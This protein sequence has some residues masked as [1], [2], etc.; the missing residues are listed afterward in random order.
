VHN[1]HGAHGIFTFLS[2]RDSIPVRLRTDI[3]TV[4]KVVTATTGTAMMQPV[5]EHKS[6]RGDDTN[7]DDGDNE[8]YDEL[9]NTNPIENANHNNTTT[10]ATPPHSKQS[11]TQTIQQS[12]LS[13]P[14]PPSKMRPTLSSSSKKTTYL[15]P[16]TSKM[17]STTS[18]TNTTSTK[19]TNNDM[20]LLQQGL[21]RNMTTSKQRQQ[22]Q[23]NPTLLVFDESLMIKST[24]K[25]LTTYETPP[26]KEM[27]TLYH[28]S[29]KLQ[30]SISSLL[31]SPFS[32]QEK[33]YKTIYFIRHGESL[34]Q[35]ATTHDRRHNEKLKDCGLSPWGIRQSQQQLRH[36]FVHQQQ[37]SNN[38]VELILCSPLTRAIQT[39]ILA[40]GSDMEDE[41]AVAT[42]GHAIPSVDQKSD[43][44][45]R[46]SAS[47][48]SA[49]T[50]T[51]SATVTKSK[52]SSPKILI[53]YHLREM[54]S[55][56]P[57]NQPRT[58]KQVCDYLIRVGTIRNRQQWDTL[59]DTVTLQP[60]PPS[61][62]SSLIYYSY[63]KSVSPSPNKMNRSYPSNNGKSNVS[64]IENNAY[65]AAASST[66]HGSW[67]YYSRNGTAVDTVPSVVRRDYI[68]YMLQWI[69]VHRHET[70]IAIVCH[71]HVI[72]AALLSSSSSSMSN[73]GDHD[74]RKSN[75]STT[76]KKTRH[77]TTPIKKNVDLRPE[78]AQPIKCYLC[79]WTGQIILASHIDDFK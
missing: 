10:T 41:A 43:H 50:V 20:V 22:Q 34:G 26:K 69:A 71:Y 59:V 33:R 61:S 24:A 2:E 16:V 77:M 67:P 37:N 6:P 31:T 60:P 54:G 14:P 9:R 38:K 15:T 12:L 29:P 1:I 51:T 17:V 45:S 32:L 52:K 70:N 13:T 27:M 56:I 7:D 57:E 49:S 28:H 35:I 78:N 66:I 64:S 3:H 25:T 23:Y 8:N 73:V 74:R 11:A 30:S 46:N 75:N 65:D 58:M 18:L 42:S 55:N 36:F 39:A 44:T 62:S 21:V 47:S 79:T 72:R 4:I 19:K 63:T 68:Q 53:H 76:K 5:H 48:D 40:F